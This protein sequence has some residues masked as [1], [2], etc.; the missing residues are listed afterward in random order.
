MNTASA[1]EMT[2][3]M[4]VKPR[5]WDT[6]GGFFNEKFSGGYGWQLYHTLTSLVAVVED[7]GGTRTTTVT[8]AM[9]LDTWYYIAFTFKNGGDLVLYAQ[10]EEIDR[11]TSVGNITALK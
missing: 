11:I 8:Y 3:E 10:G 4:W 7:S 1:G 9:T 6:A 2:V 5:S